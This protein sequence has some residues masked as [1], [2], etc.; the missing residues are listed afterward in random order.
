MR[1]P[2]HDAIL[3]LPAI[4]MSL[5]VIRRKHPGCFEDRV[6][7]GARRRIPAAIP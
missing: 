1:C 3:A 2:R 7:L 6:P 4:R 5:D